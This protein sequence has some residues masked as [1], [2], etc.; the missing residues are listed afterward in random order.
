M[1]TLGFILLHWEH[2]GSEHSWHWIFPCFFFF[3][4]L[5]MCFAFRGRWRRYY[6][7][8]WPGRFSRRYFSEPEAKDILKR[9]YA[10]GEIS[11]DEFEKMK[12]DIS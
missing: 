1:K 6:S 8:G 2:L 4:F 10:K 9:R 5:F 12:N 7:C 3:M 11:K